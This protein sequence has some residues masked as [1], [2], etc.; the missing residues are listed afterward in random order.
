MPIYFFVW[1]FSLK[2]KCLKLAM[3]ISPLS[4]SFLLCVVC[5]DLSN[6]IPWLNFQ[7]PSGI[8]ICHHLSH[9]CT[10]EPCHK[11]Q[12]HPWNHKFYS[13]NRTSIFLGLLLRSLEDCLFDFTK[14]FKSQI[15]LLSPSF[16]FTFFLIQLWFL[17]STVSY[18]HL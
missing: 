10:I 5:S 7:R 12:F 14:I 18:Q 6:P 15:P 11:E 3:S 9:G 2:C 4:R 17:W 13:V 16:E 1:L 8:Y